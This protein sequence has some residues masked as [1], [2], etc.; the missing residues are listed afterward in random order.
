MV[1]DTKN[2]I[3]QRDKAHVGVRLVRELKTTWAAWLCVH[4]PWQDHL[5]FHIGISIPQK[6]TIWKI[7]TTAWSQMV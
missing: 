4:M 5:V 1:R 7:M 3:R 2:A 6:R